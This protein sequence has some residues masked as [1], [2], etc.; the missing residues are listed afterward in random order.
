MQNARVLLSVVAWG[1]KGNGE[2]HTIL[3]CLSEDQLSCSRAPLPTYPW[4]RIAVDLFELKGLTYLLAVDYYSRFVEVQKLS[5]TTSISVITHLKPLFARFGILAEMVTDNGPQFAS[6]EMKQ[7]SNTYGFWHITTSP[8]YPQANGL[9]ERTVKTVKN[10]LEHSSDPYMA[11]L[12]YRATPI[13]WCALSPVELLMGRRI[14]TD[15]PQVTTSFIPKWSHIKNFKILDEAHKRLQKQYY[16]KRHRVR[17]LPPLPEDQKVW[18]DTRGDLTPARVLHA[19][20]TPRSY[21]VE[22]SSGQLRRNR[23]H[24][25]IQPNSQETVPPPPITPRR[26]VTRSQTGI[27]LVLLID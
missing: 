22:T 23:S 10:L 25:R 2:L 1:V 16:D 19:A 11:L 17:E 4:E 20:D 13:P 26:P 5:S 24:L 14:R 7:F 9:A 27:L 18:V 12:S 3:F 15:V 21:V 6:Y 8:H